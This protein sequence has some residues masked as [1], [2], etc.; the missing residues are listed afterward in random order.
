MTNLKDQI[1]DLKK[2]LNAVY[3]PRVRAQIIHELKELTKLS[4][5]EDCSKLA[6]RVDDLEEKVDTLAEYLGD[7]KAELENKRRGQT[8]FVK[9]GD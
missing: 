6:K 5:M 8:G 1:K 7:L 4:N 3:N 2:K 9:V